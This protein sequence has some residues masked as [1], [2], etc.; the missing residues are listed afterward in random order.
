MTGSKF[1]KKNGVKHIIITFTGQLTN[2]QIMDLANEVRTYVKN[3]EL[4]V[5]DITVD[6]NEFTEEF[7][8]AALKMFSQVS[9]QDVKFDEEGNLIV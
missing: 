5:S 2:E 4:L 8:D 7:V 9:G 1:N 6:V 3:Q